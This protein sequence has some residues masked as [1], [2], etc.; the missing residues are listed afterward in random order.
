MSKLQ[1][2]IIIDVYTTRTD[3]SGNRYS[4]ITLTNPRNG[5][6]ANVDM[7]WGGGIDNARAEARALGLEYS[8]IHTS[9]AE[10][11]T[12]KELNWVACE[13]NEQNINEAF[14]AVGLRKRA[15]KS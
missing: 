11:L 10:E 1:I 15:V 14:R 5:K 2:K 7:G 6:R 13:F 9:H 8:E 12:R 3:T 4:K